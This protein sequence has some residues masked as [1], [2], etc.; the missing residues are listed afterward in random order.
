MN[1]LLAIR[2][3]LGVQQK[4][5]ADSLGISQSGISYYESGRGDPSVTVARKLIEIAKGKG[6]SLTLDEIYSAT[7][8]ADPAVPSV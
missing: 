7:A 1:S 4:D 5:L 6:I 3:R 8:P 2:K